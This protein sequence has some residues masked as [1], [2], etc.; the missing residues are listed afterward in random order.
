MVVETCVCVC[1][2]GG[3]GGGMGG[4]GCLN[5]LYSRET[6]SFI[7]VQLQITNIGLVRIRVRCLICVLQPVEEFIETECGA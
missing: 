2:G 7:P 4:G 1:A 3:G 6:S 5:Q